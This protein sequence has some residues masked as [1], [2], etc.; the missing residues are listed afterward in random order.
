MSNTRRF[1]PSLGFRETCPKSPCIRHSRP[2]SRAVA[3]PVKQRMGSR[4]CGSLDHSL[5]PFADG[6]RVELVKFRLIVLAMDAA[7]D[8]LELA[9]VGAMRGRCRRG[10][11]AWL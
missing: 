10:W 6:K 1:V 2:R 4:D 7:N 8:R 5:N 3:L 11:F 9:L